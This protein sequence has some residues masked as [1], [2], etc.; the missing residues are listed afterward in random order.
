MCRKLILSVFIGL[1]LGLVN[2]VLAFPLMVDIGDTGQ[3]VK[4]GWE[5][6][7]GDGNNETDPKTESYLVGALTISV[8]IETGFTN[9]SGYRDYGGGDLGGDM[10]YPDDHYGSVEG[11]VIL[12]FGNLPAGDYI[13]TSYHNDSKGSHVQQDPIDVTVGGAITGS[14]SD[15]DVVQTK[16][17]DDN[18]L[19]QSTVTFTA[20]GTGD[21]VVTYTPTTDGGNESKAVLNG[22]ELD[23]TG[24]TVQFDSA[25]SA[26][27]ESG[28]AVLSVV[29]SPATPNTVTVNYNVTGGTAV[30]GG[31]DYTLAGGTLIFG[32]N[33][34]T[35]EYI[36]IVIVNDGEPEEDETI[37]V[38]LSDPVNAELGAITQHIYTILDPRP[39][40]AFDTTASEGQESVSPAYI[41]VSL[42][43]E[44]ADTVTVDYNVTG[45]TAIGGED[46]NLAY[47]TLVFE[48]CEVTKYISITIA[49]DDYEEDPDETI[50]I[51]LSSPNNAKLGINAQHTFTILPPAAHVCP[52][53][54]L[55]EN[56]EVDFNDLEILAGQW[57]DS[58]GSCTDFNC[59]DF[60]GSNWVD[61]FDFGL[62]AG[63]WRVKLCPLVINEFM[64]SND[65]T[66]M[67]PQGQYND[68][69]EFYNA[70]GITVD[71]GGMWLADSQ[72]WWQ[73][74]DD[75]PAETTVEPYGYLLIWADNDVCDT[76]GLHAGF[77]LSKSGD[78]V[79]LYAADAV[80]LIDSIEFKTQVSDIS[81]GRYPDASENLRFFATP[82]PLAQNDG[83]YLGEV[84]DTKFSHNRGFYES[85]FNVSITCNTE[86]AVIHYTLNG[87]EP[88]EFEGDG[89]YAYTGPIDINQTTTLRAAAFKPGYLPANVDTQTYI[90]LDD[91]I[92][93]PDI[94]QGVVTTYG[95]GVVKDAFKSIPTLS[96]AMNASDLAN[97]QDHDSRYPS[98]GLP[99]M[100]LPTSAELIYADP[101]EGEGLQINCAIEGHSWALNKRSYKL[102]FKSAFGPT[103]LRY[104]FLESAPVNADSA[105]DEFDRI[106]LRA[107]KNMPV[108]YA[109]DQWTRDSQIAMSDVSA[110]GAY[111]HLYL[112]GTYWGLYNATERPD[113]WFTSSY[114]GG[115]KE[116]YFATNHGYERGEDHISGDSTRFDTMISMAQAQNLE[117]PCNYETFKGLCDAT[118]FADYTILF[119]FSGFGDTID[120]NW[121]A[122]MRNVPLVGSVPPEGFMML[123]WDAEYV[124][125]N[126]A[127]PPGHYEPWVPPYYFTMTGYTIVDTWLALYEN[128]DFNILF[129]DRIYKH[130]FN[131][132]ALTDDNTQARWDTI[133]DYIDDAAICELARWP[134]GGGY[135]GPA[136]VPPETVDM[137]G[138]VNI[139]MTALDNYGGLYPSID[140]PTITPRGGY[141]PTGFAVTMSG[142]GTIYYTLDGSNPRQAV[143]GNPVG[144]PYSG[145]VVLTK[146]THVKARV[147]A[148]SEWSALNEATFAVGPVADNVRITEIMY[149][150]QDTNDPNDPN[151]EF[152]ELKNIGS[153]TLNLNLVRFTNGVDFTFPDDIDVPAGG[154]VVVVKD[155]NAFMSRYPG[156]AGVIAG[157]Y[158]GSLNNGGERIK[159][160]DAIGQTIHDFEY[161]DGWRPIT[162]GGGFSLTLIDPTNSDPNSW[163]E[164][165]SWRPSAYLGGSPGWDDAG[166]VPNPGAVV[167]NEVMAHSHLAPD[168]VELYNTTDGAIDIG[169]WFLSDSDSNLM[170][171]EI[172]PGTWIL[173]G[174]YLV[175]Y[176]DANFG[177]P[178]DPG[179]HIP[180]AFSENGEE[181][182]LSSGLDANG[183]LTGYR[184][185][186]D[187]GASDSNVSFGLY[188]KGST[189]N[190]NFVA[191]DY[192]TPGWANTYPKVGPIVI[193]EIMY[194]PDWPD[195]SLYNND[196]YEYVELYNITSADVNLYDEEG[197]RWK[198]TDG[199]EFIFPAD[200]NIPA[201]GYLL[202]VKDPVAFTWR[203]GAMPAGVEVLGPYDGKLSNGGEKLELSK[204][205]D[206]DEFGTRYYIRVDRVNYSDGSHP[207]DCPG[208]VDLWP[209]QAD[210]GGKSL[211]RIDPNLYGNDPN[212]WDAN[213]PSPG[214]VNP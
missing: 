1:L 170:K 146:S 33:Q 203:Y 43:W 107:S 28:P 65:E 140:P 74:P 16:S 57:L 10:V 61:M 124:F 79:S 122:G 90:F 49:E 68:W 114:F 89:T 125:K 199:I 205:G 73:I 152:I 101:N 62:L 133:T 8:S 86:D 173:T 71:M 194:H 158:T 171:Y 184:E 35:S 148:A 135:G 23:A 11:R 104:P 96:I 180:F 82:T 54:D 81:Y 118:N 92:N 19:G 209:I 207:E 93:Q 188:F 97:L 198:F 139:F 143:T 154:Y 34:A 18:N 59:A 39:N 185:V 157:E 85:P 77:A 25:A 99:K 145:P 98:Q 119:W 80:T 150:P 128:E 116:D 69:I 27:F 67:D 167:I 75:R 179:C 182:C 46:Y 214:T 121:Y 9:D 200:T 127:S 177:N 72:N 208:G 172:A 136:T 12:T 201:S 120:N 5:E 83:A 91:V 141:D 187:F 103:Q 58:P 102:I 165:D 202:V 52:V 26:D 213:S 45:G 160:E 3:T 132:G 174:E 38:T 109:G 53:G 137:T 40:V 159:L 88:N 197:N 212:N 142:S 94:D 100:E 36:N 64:A 70:S 7:T 163:S 211:A 190:Y 178:N 42:S 110:R 204:P 21:V 156:F 44:W 17:L 112:N 168:W 95:S 29:L 113:A 87:S 105:V 169:G 37:E 129:A 149:H 138:F 210:G 161:K 206:V 4:A 166:I 131:D 66:I 175:F 144:T 84:A 32:P 56:C 24:T 193:S 181:V 176:E 162:D 164:K 195:L 155:Q 78:E 196:D 50:E 192:N 123:M 191:M 6:F 31:Q 134:A 63:N 117:D 15:L 111:V 60:D 115:E 20:N 153:S 2:S 51:T 106:V 151:T 189:G 13:L 48:P 147:L 47:G 126:A 108:T 30:G 14:T 130:C 22:F 76:P 186:E 55:D 183:H 41:P